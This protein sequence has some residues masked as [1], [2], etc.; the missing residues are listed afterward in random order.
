MPVILKQA[1]IQ[2]R[3]LFLLPFDHCKVLRS[4]L[5]LLFVGRIEHRTDLDL[6]LRGVPTHFQNYGILL[7]ELLLG[8]TQ[9]HLLNLKLLLL[10]CRLGFEFPGPERLL[11][12]L[13]A[14]ALNCLFLEVERLLKLLDLQIFILNLFLLARQTLSELLELTRSLGLRVSLLLQQVLVLIDR[15]L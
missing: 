6:Q 15:L 2:S 11:T 13:I 3:N 10:I 5:L 8:L 14:Q 1:L 4:Q 12:Q 7:N 9:V